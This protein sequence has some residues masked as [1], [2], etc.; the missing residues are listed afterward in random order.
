MA[1]A[2]VWMLTE[3]VCERLRHLPDAALQQFVGVLSAFQS[4]RRSAGTAVVVAVGRL[5]LEVAREMHVA[6]GEIAT[7]ERAVQ[8]CCKIVHQGQCQFPYLCAHALLQAALA[9]LL[10]PKDRV[11]VEEDET[12]AKRGSARLMLEQALLLLY[13]K[14]SAWWCVAHQ[15]HSCSPHT[16]HLSGRYARPP[17]RSIQSRNRV[18][19]LHAAAAPARQSSPLH[20]RCRLRMRALHG[21]CCI[22]TSQ[23]L[24]R[25]SHV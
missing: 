8:A 16:Q 17:H 20:R 24:R 19:R 4:Y 12:L 25:C 10:P 5:Q 11:V 2:F 18:R 13:P 9:L 3:V 6:G 15:R 7:C 14:V 21:Q 22:R 23:Q 1:W